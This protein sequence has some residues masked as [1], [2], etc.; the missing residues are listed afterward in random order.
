VFLRYARAKN[1]VGCEWISQ[2]FGG[3][4]KTMIIVYSVFDGELVVDC[5]DIH[6]RTRGF[7]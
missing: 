2:E 3:C 5:E 4:V 7:L 6:R 1:V